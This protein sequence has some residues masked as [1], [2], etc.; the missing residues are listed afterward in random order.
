MG[1]VLCAGQGQPPKN[2][3]IAQKCWVMKVSNKSFICLGIWLSTVYG[4]VQT[5]FMTSGVGGPMDPCPE[6]RKR[7]KK[8]KKGREMG[9]KTKQ[10]QGSKEKQTNLLN[11][12]L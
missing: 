12:I 9:L 6:K 10:Q 11:K 4:Q 1:E 8:R 7:E 3:R 2:G 5:G